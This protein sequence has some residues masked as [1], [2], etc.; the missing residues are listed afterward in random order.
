MVHQ[1][2][3][4]TYAKYNNGSISGKW[5][6]LSDYSSS[7]EFYKACKE[8][9]S[10]ESDSEFMFQDYEGIPKKFICESALDAKYWEWLEIVE[11][12]HYDEEVFIAADALD[13]EADMVEELYQGAHSTDENF[14]QE[15]ADGIGAI[16]DTLTWPHSCIDWEH[17]AR[18]LMYDYAE[19]D[20]HYFLT[21][22]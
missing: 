9:H 3:V 21:S 6:N 15:F 7:D 16:D 4:G 5:L 20:G 10:D 2:Y 12:S 22:C 17:A 14:A 1:I 18:E 8:L 11:A 13:I 19:H